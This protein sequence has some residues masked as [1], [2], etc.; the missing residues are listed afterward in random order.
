MMTTTNDAVLVV[1][2]V[3]LDRRFE[4]KMTRISPEAPSPVINLG[5]IKHSPGG[6]ANVAAN[7]VGLGR[8]TYL[9]GMVGDDAD[10][11]VLTEVMGNAGFRFLAVPG[12]SHTTVKNR[13]TPGGQQVLRLDVEPSPLLLPHAAMHLT[14]A[15][16]E[17]LVPGSPVKAVVVS[18]YNKGMFPM[19]SSV[20]TGLCQKN[21]IPLYVD[22]KPGNLSSFGQG[23]TLLKP[24]LSE[25]MAMCQGVV[26]PAMGLDDPDEAA[27]CCAQALRN[28]LGLRYV[29]V[30]CSERGAVALAPDGTF[31]LPATKQLV[32]DPTGAGDTFMATMVD[33]LMRG[34]HIGSAVSTANTAAGLAVQHHGTYVV[35]GLEL[36]EAC[37]KRNGHRTKIMSE[38]ALLEYVAYCK[39][40]GRRIVMTNGCF[41]IVHHGHMHLMQ[42][43]AVYGD[44]LIVAVNTDDS[45]RR[46][47]GDV[48]MIPQDWRAS[49]LSLLPEVSVVTLFDDVSAERIIRAV[50]P[51]VLVKGEDS[52]A[53]SVPGADFVAA[54]GGA[55]RFVPMLGNLHAKDLLSSGS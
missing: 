6:A 42:E 10:G 34:D 4:G 24:N 49:L 52:A 11:K 50:H 15:L 33:V 9:L 44:K 14:N 37:I 36:I 27:L 47:K 41:R 22:T 8:P 29:V 31:T 32:S 7:F 54:Y 55:V 21:Q 51:D 19:L 46:L 13:I 20:L 2:D 35:S 1:G 48:P 45:I 12:L 30:T 17:L 39:Q 5:Q 18:D 40:A 28:A 26:H 23:F 3:M 53:G 16:N 25:A 38:P 43:A